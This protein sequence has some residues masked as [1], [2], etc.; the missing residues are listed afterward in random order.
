MGNLRAE[1]PGLEV[2]A[3]EEKAYIV[4]TSSAIIDWALK[5]KFGLM[6]VSLPT[7][8]LDRPRLQTRVAPGGAAHKAK[9]ENKNAADELITFLWDN[10][11]ALLLD[12]QQ[13]KPVHLV[14]IGHGAGCDAIMTLLSTQDLRDITNNVRA[15]IMVPSH[16]SIPITPKNRKELRDWYYD[17][18]KVILPQD[19]SFFP[20]MDQQRLGR[21]IGRTERSSEYAPL[22]AF[23]FFSPFQN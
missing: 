6:D 5:K 10:Y 11:L 4:D 20:T 17:W 21:R 2:Y 23:S 9:E 19:H 12:D 15:V 7:Q 8:Q 3:H 22:L 16:N 1:R 18:S 14:L 13:E